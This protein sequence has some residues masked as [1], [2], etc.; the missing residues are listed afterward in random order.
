MRSTSRSLS[1]EDLQL[2]LSQ[3]LPGLEFY[4]VLWDKVCKLALFGIYLLNLLINTAPVSIASPSFKEAAFDALSAVEAPVAILFNRE[5]PAPSNQSTPK[6]TRPAPKPKTFT[7]RHSKPTFL[8]IRSAHLDW[9]REENAA[10]NQAY[11]LRCPVCLRT[12]FTSL[13]G[14]LNHA[15]LTHALEW[16]NHDACVRACA[17]VDGS[18]NLDEGVEVGVTTG[19]ILPGI[20]SLFEIGLGAHHTN[21]I[22]PQSD[23]EYVKVQDNREPISHLARTLGLHGDTPSLAPFLGKRAKR[24][25]I[26]VWDEDSFVDTH[27]PIKLTPE[28]GKSTSGRSWRMPFSYHNAFEETPLDPA[29]GVKIAKKLTSPENAATNIA[30]LNPQSAQETVYDAAPQNGITLPATRFHFASR[31]IIADHSLWI[32]PGLFNSTI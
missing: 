16:G 3:E 1:E 30:S 17:V 24:R 20:Q 15:R 23:I 32:P 31:I 7:S 11:L 21:I 6:P 2:C 29:E 27:Q 14:L 8:F 18:L 12:S 25:E 5:L 10:P 13:Q 19:G 4:R 26:R 28:T 9:A 22:A